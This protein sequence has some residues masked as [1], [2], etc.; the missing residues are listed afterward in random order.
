M[1]EKFI[2]RPSVINP[3]LWYPERPS[4][5]EWD[6]IRKIVLERDN[7]TCSYCG[8]R[9]IKYMNIHHLNETGESNPDNL[10]TICVA[11]HA[12]LHIGRNISMKIIEI[13][14]SQISQVE[15]VRRTREGIRAG[16]TL[17][18]INSKIEKNLGPYSP[19]SIE[20]A[21]GL[22]SLMG[23]RSRAFLKEPLSVIFVNLH[24][25]QIE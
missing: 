13:W 18:I 25:W 19:D 12:V 6:R 21:N 20:Y 11:C 5:T 17:E 7:F 14:E 1:S 15:I 10:A 2:L 23:D 4:K 16:E 9:A 8:H 3:K 24:R 22:I